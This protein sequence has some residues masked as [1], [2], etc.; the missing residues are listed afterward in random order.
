MN[1]S[2][3]FAFAAA[4]NIRFIFI[5]FAPTAIAVSIRI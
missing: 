3:I 5:V 4:A 2:S 1:S